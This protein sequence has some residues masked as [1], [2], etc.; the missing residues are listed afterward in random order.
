[1]NPETEAD[2]VAS[3]FINLI[4]GT[5]KRLKEKNPQLAHDVTVEMLTQLKD[6]ED[7]DDFAVLS[8][9]LVDYLIPI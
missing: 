3:D 8:D 9:T 6:S 4:D 5:L 7:T 2:K 1:M